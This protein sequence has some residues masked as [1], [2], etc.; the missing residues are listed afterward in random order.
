MRKPKRLKQGGTIALIAPASPPAEAKFVKAFENLTAL[1]FNIKP[2]K[3]MRAQFGYLAGTDEARVADIHAA[4]EDPEV[5]AIWCVRGGYGCT[6]IL[7]LL[8]FDLIREN[9]K[10]LIGYSDITALHIALLQR[11]GVVSY[12]AQVG[13][14]DMTPFTRNHLNK[15]LLEGVSDYLIPAMDTT[16][17]TGPEYQ[18]WTIT[19]GKAK[20]PLTGGNLAVLSAMAGTAFAP[21]FKNKIAFIEDIGEAPYRIDRMLT[22]LIQATDLRQANGIVLGIF[23]DCEQKGDT[24]TLKLAETLKD[25]LAGLGMPVYYGAPFGHIS[26]QCVMPYGIEAEM[27]ADAMTLRLLETAVG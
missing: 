19:A 11:A 4:F 1:G 25:R 24:P 20:G 13:G 8:N 26:D 10:P 22:Q 16:L 18:P 3:N 17:R 12:H 5:D 21:V 27:D 6:R 7:P 9:P 15:T 2:G 23:N 14:G